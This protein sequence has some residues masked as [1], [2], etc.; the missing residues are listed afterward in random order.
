MLPEEATLGRPLFVKPRHGHGH[1]DAFALVHQDGAW[2][3]NGRSVSTADLQ[4]R[5]EQASRRDDLLLQERLLA[6]TELADL[7]VDDRAPVLRLVTARQPG[8]DPFLHS[9]MLTLGVPDRDPAHFLEGAIHVPVDA[10]TGHLLRG[11]CLSRPAERLEHLPW[12]LAPLTG[13]RLPH[14]DDAVGDALAAMSALPPLPLVHWDVI[15]TGSGPVF[16]EGN[17]SG[18]WIIASLP[19]LEGQGACDLADLL[20]CWRPS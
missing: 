11:I 17:S 7:A 12:K 4:H 1:R 8:G 2:L 20:A 5:L 6:I 9:A 13:R 19:G 14:F 18:N 3:V 10:A 16:L 15:L